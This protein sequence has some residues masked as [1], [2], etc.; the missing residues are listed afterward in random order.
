MIVS[1]SLFICAREK[2]SQRQDNALR[3]GLSIEHVKREPELLAQRADR[4][5][6]ELL[7]ASGS[8]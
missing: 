2:P 7:A 4:R 3:E 6:H 5:Y 8:S 1:L